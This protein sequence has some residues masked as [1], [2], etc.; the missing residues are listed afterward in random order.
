MKK[1]FLSLMMAAAVVAT[2]SVSAFAAESEN[3]ISGPESKTYESKIEMTGDVLNDGGLSVPGTLTV[4]V[5]TTA[6]F[7]VDQ[8]GV[9]S[10]A[11]IR[12]K[13][14]GTQN[15]QVFAYEFVDI[16]GGNQGI[17]VTN[18]AALKD[19]LT[20][21][22]RNNITLKIYGDAGTAYLSSNST[23][24]GVHKNPE[25]NQAADTDDGI[26]LATI[27]AS[28]TGELTLDGEAGKG[29]L[30]DPVRDMFTLKLKIKKA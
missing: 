18:K 30:A 10:A 13:N 7:T 25:L 16:N 15:I 12:I 29:T 6:S 19:G 4:T 1:K 28:K 8:S 26:K 24:R 17:N 21:A 2:T 27:N 3:V 11:K 9:L 20:D 14:N 5:P 22:A 23:N